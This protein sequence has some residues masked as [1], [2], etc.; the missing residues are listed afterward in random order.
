MMNN[1]KIGDRITYIEENWRDIKKNSTGIIID[2][3]STGL[4]MVKWDDPFLENMAFS[5]YRLEHTPTPSKLKTW[6]SKKSLD[7][8]L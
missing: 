6:L 7:N 1:F 8:N 4:C 2:M 5:G 3:S